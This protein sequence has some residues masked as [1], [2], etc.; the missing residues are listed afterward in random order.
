M[1]RL[2][3]LCFCLFPFLTQASMPPEVINIANTCAYEKSIPDKITYQSLMKAPSYIDDNDSSKERTFYI[4][5]NRHIIGYIESNKRN[6][7]LYDEKFYPLSNT[8][9]LDDNKEH[10]DDIDHTLISWGY[11]TFD[12]YKY[13][14]ASAPFSGIGESGQHQYTRGVYVFNPNDKQRSLYFSAINTLQE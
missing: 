10:I 13:I 4:K 6:G 9:F 11:V 8:V 1:K 3:L 12:H 14:C 7:F 5:D 2:L